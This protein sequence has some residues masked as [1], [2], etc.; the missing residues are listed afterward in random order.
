MPAEHSSPQNFVPYTSIRYSPSTKSH[1]V[2]K[3]AT[4]WHQESGKRCKSQRKER[5]ILSTNCYH[6]ILFAL[7]FLETFL[8][9]MFSCSACDDWNRRKVHGRRYRKASN[10]AELLTEKMKCQWTKRGRKRI[11]IRVLIGDSAATA[12]DDVS[13]MDCNVIGTTTATNTTLAACP[14]KKHASKTAAKSA[15]KEL[16]KLVEN[17][18]KDAVA[19]QSWIKL[20]ILSQQR[21]KKTRNESVVQN[22]EEAFNRSMF[23]QLQLKKE[24]TLT[25]QSKLNLEERRHSQAEESLK[26]ERLKNKKLQNLLQ[27]YKT[28]LKSAMAKRLTSDMKTSSINN[29]TSD[30]LVRKIEEAFG[31][32]KGVLGEKKAAKLLEMIGAGLL[33]IL[34]ALHRDN[35]RNK[36]S[37][38]KLVCASDMSPAGSFHSTTVSGLTEFFDAQEDDAGCASCKERKDRIFPSTS[39]VSR[40]RVA[41]NNFAIS[42]LGL[43]RKETPY[44]EI[45]LCRCRESY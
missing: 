22:A 7:I 28:R 29:D 2:S 12:P 30:S 6:I 24:K 45:L 27:Y 20:A 32:M 11:R 39:K 19:A 14:E 33:F 26:E 36:F 15:A 21:D 31:V 5:V 38:R 37:A 13:A 18:K 4:E 23:I 3:L 17:E 43:S 16:W 41:L 10:H 35:V 40:E 42:E 34:E 44:G 8:K 1:L 9:G 25:I